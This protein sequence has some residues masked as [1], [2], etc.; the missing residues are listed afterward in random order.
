MTSFEHHPRATRASSRRCLA[1]AFVL[2]SLLAASSASAQD[3]AA[4]VLAQ[5]G[6]ALVD[7]GKFDAGCPKLEEA[8]RL[9]PQLLGAGFSLGECHERGGKLASAWTVFMS[10]AG[11]AAARGEARA[12]EA[13]ARADKLKPKLSTLTIE[14]PADVAGA[15]GLEV[16][17]GDKPVSSS[18]FGTPIPRDG[19]SVTVVVTASGRPPWSKQV[20]VPSEGGKIDVVA[21]LG[22]TGSSD[23]PPSGGGGDQQPDSAGSTFWKPLRI[24]GVAAVSLGAVGLGLG[25]TFGVLAMQKRDESNEAG[26][27]DPD[28]NFCSSSAGVELRS[29]SLLYGDVST[30]MFVV[31][32]VAAAAGVVMM[33]VPLSDEPTAGST[34]RVLIGPTSVAL[35]GSFQ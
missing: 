10:V 27:C 20:D 21:Q 13:Q 3:P 4:R 1:S 2:A 15:A 28:T 17:L 35:E 8:W 30:A 18:L 5:E 14:V 7:A 23:A 12:A 24:G 25:A 9:D 26:G 32:G 11:K 34:A 6:K 16:K 33:V 29:E 31:G 22:S 19:G